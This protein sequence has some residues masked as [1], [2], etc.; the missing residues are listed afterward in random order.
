MMPSPY[1]LEEDLGMR[2]YASATPGI[3]G[4]LR[5]SPA[6]FVVE[7]LPLPISDPDGPYIICRLTKT[8]W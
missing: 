8:N 4:H 1:P 5:S 3:G 2:Y 6:D 7:E